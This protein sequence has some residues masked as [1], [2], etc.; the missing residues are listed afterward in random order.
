MWMKPRPSLSQIGVRFTRK[1]PL[2]ILKSSRLPEHSEAHPASHL[3]FTHQLKI[4]QIDLHFPQ[5]TDLRNVTILIGCLTT[6]PRRIAE[7]HIR[8]ISRAV[9]SVGASTHPTASV[10][11]PAARRAF[12][13]AVSPKS[14]PALSAP[15][16]SDR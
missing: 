4:S 5:K 3:R 15:S 9:A 2:V 6:H 16:E 13:R 11:C 1:T 12:S 8:R 7:I 10:G 14:L